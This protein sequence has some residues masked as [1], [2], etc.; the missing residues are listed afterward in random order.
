MLVIRGEL[1]KKYPTAV[2][3]AHRADWQKDEG[4]DPDPTQERVL[5]EVEAFEEDHPPRTKVRTPLYE[6]K[7]P[8]DFYFFGFDLTVPEAKGG[9]GEPGDMDPGWFFV[10]K[11]RP[12]DPRFGFD[13]EREEDEQL[14]TFNDLSWAD[15]LAS[16]APG[17]FVPAGALA[18]VTFAALGDDDVEKEDQRK[19]D[20]KVNPAPANAARWAYI[21]YQAP[22]MVAIHAAEML[23][24]KGGA[25]A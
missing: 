25:S 22:V 2:I 9:S 19:E 11:E 8:P 20:D 16:V 10:I 12:G 4:G 23:R 24:E 7:V 17:G 6:A 1:L 18:P 5:V 3:Y 13:I 15:D 21:L 14:Q